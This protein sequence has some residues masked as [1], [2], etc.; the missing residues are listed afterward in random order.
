MARG[1]SNKRW[2][3]SAKRTMNGSGSL[4]SAQVVSNSR[5][6]SFPQ[7]R[8]R[9]RSNERWESNMHGANWNG[10]VLIRSF[11]VTS[12]KEKR[13]VSGGR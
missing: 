4:Y 3:L 2:G 9:P 11:S 10:C 12:S 1:R 6:S 7:I 8:T 13:H 5:R